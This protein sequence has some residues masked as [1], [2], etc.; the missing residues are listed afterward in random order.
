M[1]IVL[2]CS[3]TELC[4]RGY[5]RTLTFNV[6]LWVCWDRT[7]NECQYQLLRIIHNSICLARLYEEA[8]IFK[9]LLFFLQLTWQ[10]PHTKTH[11]EAQ[12]EVELQLTRTIITAEV[13]RVFSLKKIH[14]N[15]SSAGVF[16]YVCIVCLCVSG[17]ASRIHVTFSSTL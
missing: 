3:I 1:C 4:L 10:R 16:M 11:H 9:P 15:N 14:S 7:G 13:Q 5:L 8:F 12:Q 2:K 6:L 17:K